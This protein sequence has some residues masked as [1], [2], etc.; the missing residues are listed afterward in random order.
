MNEK[1][2]RTNMRGLILLIGSMTVGGFIGYVFSSGAVTVPENFNLNPSIYYE[3]DVM[4]GCIALLSLLLAAFTVLGLA[5]T[6]RM[7]DEP[8]TDGE[9]DNFKDK[10]LSRVMQFSYY[11]MI[12]TLSWLLMSFA[13]A[14]GPGGKE[15]EDA[16][17]MLANMITALVFMLFSFYLLNRTFAL[18]NKNYPDRQLDLSLGNSQNAQRELF[19]KMDEGERWIVYRSSYSS[20]KATTVC[21]VIGMLF[22]ALY[23]LLFG[24]VPMPL[25]VLALILLIQQTVYYRE[26]R[27][28]S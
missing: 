1:R 17:F 13:H 18:Y 27:K 2:K 5:Q 9:I 11:T 8:K 26:V 3:Y 14:L 20:Y 24:F 25:I 12:I 16:A 21:L 19:A 28:Y 10:A 7:K 4:F 22:F 23:S 15:S 6:R